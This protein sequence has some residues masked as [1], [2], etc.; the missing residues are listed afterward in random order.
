MPPRWG[1]SG[2]HNVPCASQLGHSQ[3]HLPTEGTKASSVA[4]E[5]N[6]RPCGPWLLLVVEARPPP[7]AAA[8][9]LVDPP[10]P[11]L[12]ATATLLQMYLPSSPTNEWRPTAAQRNNVDDGCINDDFSRSIQQVPNE[13][14]RTK[15][16]T[17]C[18]K[19]CGVGKLLF[20]WKLLLR[21]L[22]CSDAVELF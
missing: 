22:L 5:H 19:C 11:G 21:L 17:A 8:R 18:E 10:P 1:L 7:K 9:R 4:V 6:A 3:P 16:R 2:P 12:A 15:P 14:K 20:A 13:G